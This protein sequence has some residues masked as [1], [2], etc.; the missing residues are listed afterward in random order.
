MAIGPALHLGEVAAAA[1]FDHVAGE[2][3]RGAGEAQQRRLARQLRAG[4]AD[5]LIDRRQLLRHACPGELAEISGI[6][7]RFELGTFAFLEPDFLAERVGNHEDVG[8]DDGGIEP[9]AAYRLQGD[10]DRLVGRVAELE[11]RA[12]RRPDRAILRQIAPGLAH[13]PDRRRRKARSGQRLQEF[14]GAHCS[15]LM[16]PLTLFIIGSSSSRGCATWGCALL[17]GRPQA[18]VDRPVPIR[19]AFT[20]GFPISQ[21]IPPSLSAGDGKWM[22]PDGPWPESARS[23]RSAWLS[24]SCPRQSR[25][26]PRVAVG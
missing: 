15:S 7:Q 9:E 10:L 5:R 12:C 20:A 14:P 18:A 22:G 11:E 17:V 24:P 13:Q 16:L 2:R 3:E 6:G 26:S 23:D 4:P 21:G 1:A 19:R 8:K 25:V